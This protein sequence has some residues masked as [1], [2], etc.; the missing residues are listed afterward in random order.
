LLQAA[1]LSSSAGDLRSRSEALGL[2]SR[3]YLQEGRTSDA[4]MLAR[5]ALFLAAE[6]EA[7]DLVYRWQ[8]Q[9]AHL[10]LRTGGTSAALDELR[11]AA[12][13]VRSMGPSGWE[14]NSSLP[15]SER[16]EALILELV[17]ALLRRADESADIAESQKLLREARDDVEALKVTELRDY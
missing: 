4:T 6:A 15:E 16:P 1:N 2:A 3:I 10:D 11:R 13:T 17:D 8:W 9:L 14:L 7:A 5:Q 12:A